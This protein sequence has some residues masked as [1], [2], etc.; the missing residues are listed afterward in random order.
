MSLTSE[1]LTVWPSSVW[2]R[3]NSIWVENCWLERDV[4]WIAYTLIG[5]FSLLA[6]FVGLFLYMRYH[7]KK[8]DTWPTFETDK[9]QLL[10]QD[11]CR[12]VF[13]KT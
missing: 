13:V 4:S 7:R 9:E 2:L 10:I 5:L 6:L 8:T 12:K 11:Q 1:A 3:I